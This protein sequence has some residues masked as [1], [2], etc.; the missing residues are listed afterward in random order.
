MRAGSSTLRDGHSEMS[1]MQL[2]E[3]LLL[4][5]RHWMRNAFVFD[6]VFEKLKKWV[7]S[8]SSSSR[9]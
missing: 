3:S 4:H 8:M 7:G 5:W 1:A 6:S 9:S 2:S